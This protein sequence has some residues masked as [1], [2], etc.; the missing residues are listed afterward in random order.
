[1]TPEDL[2]AGIPALRDVKYYNWGASG[3]SPRRVVDAVESTL[4]YHEYESA[5]GE[6]MYPA[7][8]E[9]FDRT[10]ATV[11][12]FIGTDES[13][14]AL[15]QSTTDG[16]NRVAT[17]ID[18]SPGD[19]VVTTDLEHSAGKLPWRRLERARDVDVEVIETTDGH[20]DV[21]AV[22]DAVSDA[23]LL[24]VSALDWLYG[25]THPIAN[26]VDVAH[27]AGAYTLV[28]AVQVPGQRPL[29]VRAW[30]A[31][32]VA[33]AGHKWLLGPWGA[34]FLY[35]DPAI[36]EDVEPAHV[37]SRSV[38][39]SN[40]ADYE[41]HPGAR[42]FEVGTTSPAPYAG[43]REAIQTMESIGLGTV[44][45]RIE[46]LTDRFKDGI[47]ADRL[48]SPHEYQSGLVTVRVDDPEGIVERLAEQDI[49]IRALPLPE[50]VRVSIHAFNTESEVDDVGSALAAAWS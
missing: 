13:A 49:A 21:E 45:D 50:S 37:G 26:L 48:R 42:R 28:D 18:W 38:E 22:A 47:P 23:K 2:R 14:I 24:C 7:A 4:E 27:E 35:V 1:M 29:D 25:Q 16:I 10:R 40:V 39:D 20:L 30:G 17:A 34:G 5:A 31:D 12:D 9:V 44:R 46:T 33:G 3:P 32:F 36:V 6:G 19:R 11:A 41:L 8:D 43:L 15:T